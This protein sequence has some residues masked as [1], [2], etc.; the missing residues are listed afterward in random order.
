MTRDRKAK[1]EEDRHVG[2]RW[3]AREAGLHGEAEAEA[4]YRAVSRVLSRRIGPEETRHL[5]SHLPLGL[6][7]V[8]EEE[9]ADVTHAARFDLEQLVADVQRELGVLDSL[10]ARW[11]IQIVFAWLR[12]L[13][14][15][16]RT[17]VAARLPKDIRDLWEHAT[18]AEIAVAHR[19]AR[20]SS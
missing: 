13:A 14:P 8:W 16:E 9:T 17:D 11:L 19:H 6:R 3:L 18:L 12:H 10:D 4:T 20:H 15:E 7:D 2:F 5:A 1:A